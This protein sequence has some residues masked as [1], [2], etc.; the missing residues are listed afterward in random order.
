MALMAK[1]TL[2]DLAV[3]TA[4]AVHRNFRKAADELHLASSSV[5]HT[6]KDLEQKLGVRLFNRTTRSVSLTQA[7]E[8]FLARLTPALREVDTAFEALDTFKS[9]PSGTVRINAQEVSA[10]LL[11]KHV[12]PVVLERYPDVSVD[13]V[14]EG[15]LV[16]IVAEGFDAG[17]RLG[18]TLPQDMIAASFGGQARFVA[19][20][21]PAYL[22]RAGT[23]IV[24]DD[25][26]RYACIRHR[27]PSGKLYDWEFSRHGQE[28]TV[29]VPGRL[30]LDLLPLM[31]QAA[32]DGLGIAYVPERVAEEL[33]EGGRLKRVLEDWTP[34]IPGLSLYYPSRRQVPPALRV[35]ID[36]LKEV[37]P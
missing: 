16:D 9:S 20:A 21:A 18:E 15:R 31:A 14:A 25:L 36:T 23:P 17:V 22:K 3:F 4:V 27:M 6:I 2:N 10:R 30:T 12:V 5:S 8:T 34:P 33:L 35:F 24:P 29:N 11:L 13:I 7:G 28:L 1:P 26:H 19:V 32:A 37:L